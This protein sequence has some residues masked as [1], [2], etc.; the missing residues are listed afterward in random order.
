M[1]KTL[2]INISGIV[3][4]ID[5]DAF[6]KLKYYLEAL[7]MRFNQEE[8]RD[9]IMTDIESRIA[10]LLTQRN[11]TSKQVVT[12]SD[13]D[14]VISVMG[15]PQEM[16][17]DATT[18]QTNHNRDYNTADNRKSRRR[19]FRDP[20]DAV[21]G[22][23]CSGLGHYFDVDPLW[24]RLGFVLI[25]FAF[26]TGF[27]F[28]LLLMIIIPKAETTA[29]KLEM[30]GEAAD[31]NNIH[32]TIKEEFESFGDRMKNFGKD[33][34]QFGR[35]FKGNVRRSGT[36]AERILANIFEVMGRLLAFGLVFIGIALLIGLL[37]STFTINEFGP[38]ELGDGIESFFPNS[39]VYH[40]AVTAFLLSFGIPIL[41]MIYWGI[42]M[43]F[44]I[45]NRQR[46]VGITALA[47]WV[48]GLVLGGYVIAKTASDY[49]EESR[50]KEIIAL[51]QPHGDTLI[52]DV[53][54]D[55]E[56]MNDDYD[57]NWN[58]R[59][60]LERRWKGL[61][62]K[63]NQP[64]FGYP[65]L[66]IV[67]SNSDSFELVI[68]QY[69]RGENERVALQRSKEIKYQV[70][71]QDSLLLLSSY[72]TIGSEKKWRGQRVI[73]ELRVPKN[74]VI[75]LRPNTSE[76]LDDVDNLTNTYD[77]DM[78]DRRWKMT[79]RGLA[80]ID[81]AGLEA[82][83]GTRAADYPAPIPPIPPVPP[84]EPNKDR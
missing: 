15:E 79:E 22:G 26:G 4:H 23:V 19:F 8:G 1:K 77:E 76:V 82:R 74:K 35:D 39:T 12:I 29:D 64:Y 47:L 81:C 44:R 56:M 50:V 48:T 62:F 31:V 73:A 67:P 38:V 42:K 16:G 36:T 60:R 78:A 63:D 37:T 21:V 72:F 5:E 11:G 3:F 68:Y 32:R 7:R 28:Y 58:K 80:C 84:I 49:K 46:F 71:S 43:I 9:E 52:V 20:D 33:A 2:T 66:K 34:D 41:M 69:A 70:T 59:H 51:D 25:F 45:K 61:H 18:E 83:E 65:G 40:L 54:I 55:P 6:D 17:G 30:R 10:E 13:V 27:L 24:I 57:S 75:H 53:Q 14:H